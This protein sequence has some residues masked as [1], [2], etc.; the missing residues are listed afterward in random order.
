MSLGTKWILPD[1]EP[2]DIGGNF[3]I[4][5]QCV[6]E[7]SMYTILCECMNYIHDVG[8]FVTVYSV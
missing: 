7:T 8:G 1:V 6:K 4:H 5:L 3:G 2:A